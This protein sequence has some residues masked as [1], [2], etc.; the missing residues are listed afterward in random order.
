VHQLLESE[1]NG[2]FES[3]NAERRFVE[4]YI[5]DRRFVRGVIGGDGVNGAV[6]EAR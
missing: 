5:F 4:L 3:E 6:G 2:S 1:A